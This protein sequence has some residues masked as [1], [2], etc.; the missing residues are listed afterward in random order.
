MN[1]SKRWPLISLL[2]LS[3]VSGCMSSR[4]RLVPTSR[5]EEHVEDDRALPGAPQYQSLLIEIDWVA[6]YA[7]RKEALDALETCASRWCAKPEGIEV[8]IDEEL[9]AASLPENGVNEALL[10]QLHQAHASCA[11]WDESVYYLYVLYVPRSS[12]NKALAETFLWGNGRVSIV[13]YRQ[14]VDGEA[15]LGVSAGEV[16]RLVLLHEFGH[17]LGL[18]GE[19]GGGEH[20][21]DPR[22]VMWKGFDKR[23]AVANLG[24]ILLRGRLPESFCAKCRAQLSGGIRGDGAGR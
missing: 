21:D 9:P 4:P 16:E 13:V 24:G 19:G 10:R 8:C 18:A 12:E 5:E 20:C 17:V 14:A 15:V 23:S 2:A 22:C 6:G 3:V 1:H 7:P 11:P